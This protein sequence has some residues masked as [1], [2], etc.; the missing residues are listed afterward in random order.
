MLTEE[1]PKRPSV[2]HALLCTVLVSSM[3]F[4]MLY[5]LTFMWSVY[6]KTTLPKSIPQKEF[7]ERYLEAF[8]SN[9]TYIYI[10]S[11]CV[12]LLILALFF[13]LRRRSFTDAANIK[14]G[15]TLKICSAFVCGL[16]LQIP[17]GFLISAIPFNYSIFDEHTEMM[18]SATSS[19][20]IQILYAVIVAPIAEEIVFRGIAHDRLS[21][22]M[23]VPLAALISS[24]AF[25]V[26]HGEI[27]AIIA[28]FICGYILA[29]L[30][31]RYKTVLVPIAFHIGFN[32]FA[33]TVSYLEDPVLMIAVSLASI[34]LFIGSGYLLLRRDT[35]DTEDQI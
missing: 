14:A 20:W 1:K 2:A 30:Y 25:A 7:T 35:A 32:L 8:N 27:I 5:G 9:C 3:Y 17:L 11:A 10:I 4:G 6:Y 22:T 28:A 29:L 33:Y 34:A 13:G 19:L 15:S 23:P 24:A 21:K 31:S 16:T 12:C 18:T 26:I